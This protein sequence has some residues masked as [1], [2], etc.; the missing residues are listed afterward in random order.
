MNLIMLDTINVYDG[1]IAPSELEHVNK[2]VNDK[3]YTFGWKSHDDKEYRHWNCNFG[4]KNRTRQNDEL[5]QEEIPEL[6]WN[7][8][9]RINKKN[10][11]LIRV[12]SNAYT[13]GTEGAFHQD[14]PDSNYYTH[15]IYLNNNWNPD[16][17][18]ETVFMHN[19]EIIKAVLPKYGRLVIFPGNIWHAARSV[20]HLCPEAR[21]ILVFK[22]MT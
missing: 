12:Y 14:S 16:Y 22:G 21:K 18:G 5:N 20:S 10:L 1:M 4:D 9:S 17:A 3:G 7:I 19:A 15:L 8:W 2:L 6:L 13:Y 11:R